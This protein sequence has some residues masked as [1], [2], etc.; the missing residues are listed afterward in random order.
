MEKSTLWRACNLT[1]F[2][3]S[4]TS[5]VCQPFASC[6]E[7]PG[8][9]PQGVLMWNRDSS[10]SDVSRQHTHY[11]DIRYTVYAYWYPRSQHVMVN[12][13]DTSIDFIPIKVFLTKHK[14]IQEPT[15]SL[16]DT[17]EPFLAKNIL[18]GIYNWHEGVVGKADCSWIQ[19]H[20]GHP[21]AC[22]FLGPVTYVTSK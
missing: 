7:G 1:T 19:R 18:Y 8:F 14:L 13:W 20:H 4:L 15:G 17:C 12:S 9:N 3:H 21:F 11:Y 16:S 10:V 5:P 22:C 2:I 6:H